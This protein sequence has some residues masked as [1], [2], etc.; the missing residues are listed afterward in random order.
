MCQTK[1]TNVVAYSYINSYAHNHNSSA[2]IRGSCDQSLEKTQHQPRSVKDQSDLGC[3]LVLIFSLP[4]TL[5]PW[6][7][8][9]L[10]PWILKIDLFI[11]VKIL[12]ACVMTPVHQG[13]ISQSWCGD[14]TAKVVF[15]FFFFLFLTQQQHGAKLW[16]LLIWRQ[17]KMNVVRCGVTWFFLPV[18]LP[19]CS[20][21]HRLVYLNN[22]AGDGVEAPL[23]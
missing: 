2:N 11:N 22:W 10:S 3:H 9:V 12:H 16:T 23:K 4:S 17:C 8:T 18:L 6:P 5:A 13:F 1:E 19:T 7:D 21:F 14:V 20:A 15:L